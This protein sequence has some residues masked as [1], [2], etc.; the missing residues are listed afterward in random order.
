MVRSLLYSRMRGNLE[1]T[2][3]PRANGAG[4]SGGRQPVQAPGRA[5]RHG[6]AL[7]CAACRGCA[8]GGRWPHRHIH[9]QHGRQRNKH[10]VRSSTTAQH[11]HSVRSAPQPDAVLEELELAP[12]GDDAHLE[13]LGA[14]LCEALEVGGAQAQLVQQQDLQA[15]SGAEAGGQAG[16]RGVALE[17]GTDS[18]GHFASSIGLWLAVTARCFFRGMNHPPVAASHPLNRIPLP[19]C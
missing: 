9:Q 15:G 5:A 10:S 12:H 16:G 7:L 11:K 18:N 17:R 19:A 4:G 13:D 6:A 8:G 2:L 3:V 14:R 1:I